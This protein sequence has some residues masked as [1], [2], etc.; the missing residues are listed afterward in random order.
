MNPRTIFEKRNFLWSSLFLSTLREID[1]ILCIFPYIRTHMAPKRTKVPEK[2]IEEVDQVENLEFEGGEGD[3][4]DEGDFFEG[5]MLAFMEDE[6]DAMTFCEDED[7]EDFNMNELFLKA[8]KEEQKGPKSNTVP[9]AFKGKDYYEILGVARDATP[10]EINKAYKRLSLKHHPD[11][12]LSN[13]HATTE[14]QYL[15]KIHETLAKDPRKRAMYDLHGDVSNDITSDF[16]D[17]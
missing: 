5:D 3:E 4:G 1:S 8:S 12:N 14:F 13:P 17:A 2:D 7:A 11:R 16:V 10:E 6:G 15:A 9:D